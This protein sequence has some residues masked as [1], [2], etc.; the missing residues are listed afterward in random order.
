MATV[1]INGKPVTVHLKPSAEA[2]L[3]VLRHHP[4][5]CAR[6][7]AEYD[8]YRFGARIHELRKLGWVIT[9]A[10][11]GV[12]LHRLPAYTLEGFNESV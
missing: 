1:T 8:L 6:T 12:H 2:V 4:T 7:F 3:N 9:S 11:C 5:V 10:P